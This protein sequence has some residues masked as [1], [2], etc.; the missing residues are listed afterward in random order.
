MKYII[1]ILRQKRNDINKYEE[2]FEYENDNLNTSL[3]S[4]ILDINEKYDANIELE[5]SCH[6]KKCGACSAIVN[7]SPC[8]LCQAKLKDYKNKIYIEPL[9]KFNTIVDLI[10]DRSI[11]YKN[12]EILKLWLD[13]DAKINDKNNDLVY[14]SS[15]C[16][17]CGLCLEVCPNYLPDKL[18]L[19]PSIFSLTTKIL[20]EGDNNV[21]NEIIKNYKKRIFEGCGKSLSCVNVCPKNIK[22]DNLLVN[23]N[24]LIKISKKEN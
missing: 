15:E 18:F 11:L 5:Y 16:I 21:K 6:Q 3:L 24:K 20:S 12:L 10:V 14:K 23:I 17:L 9:R 22:L 13:E 7:N 1:T 4:V 19:G 2:S 8:L